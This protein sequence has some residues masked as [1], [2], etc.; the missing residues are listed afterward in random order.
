MN[1]SKSKVRI[2]PLVSIACITYNQESFID[3]AIESFIMQKTSFPFEI[4]IH[5]DASTD[6]TL[7]ILQ[8]YV[9]K[10]PNFII[11]I[12]QKKNQVSQGINP[13]SEFVFPNCSGKYIAVCEGDDY[14]ID[15]LKL[16]KQVDFMESNPDYSLCFHNAEIKHEG[17]KGKNQLFC[18]QTEQ[19][20]HDILDAIKRNGMPTAS[21]LFR[22]K[23]M[24]IPEWLK[25]IYNG[26]YALHL[27]LANNGKIKYINEVMSVYRKNQGGF[28]AKVKNSEVWFKIYEL[29]SYFDMFTNFKYHEQIQRRK[30]ELRKM[31]KQSIGSERP[32]FIK[33]ITP[34]FYF[35]KISH[36]F[37][38]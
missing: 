24:E 10:F 18:D 9:E 3:Q 34:E 11:P 7:V 21:M 36:F 22:K 29:L 4:V 8:K 5:D 2:I 17:V 28:S 20:T 27:I 6:S 32:R 35:A 12:F 19:E 31:V 23:A 33:L 13:L 25:H 14:W 38:K 26:D 30:N 16:Q 37:I 1:Q 15:P